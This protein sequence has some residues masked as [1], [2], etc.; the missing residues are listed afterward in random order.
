MLKDGQLF[1]SADVYL[2]P[3]PDYTCEDRMMKMEMP[4]IRTGFR[5]F[6]KP[7]RKKTWEIKTDN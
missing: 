4:P 1:C 3:P 6:Y 7:Q 5:I 2:E